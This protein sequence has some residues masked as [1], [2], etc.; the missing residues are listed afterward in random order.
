MCMGCLVKANFKI[1]LK[2]TVRKP[3]IRRIHSTPK[4]V[5]P[6]CFG[7]MI[8]SMILPLKGD[9]MKRSW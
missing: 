9:F 4:A 5:E 3:N 2:I 7:G 8:P 6:T 1:R